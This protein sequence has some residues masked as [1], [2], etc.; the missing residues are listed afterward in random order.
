MLTLDEA[1]AALGSIGQEHVLRFWDGLGGA[2]RKS[3]LAQVASLNLGE[4]PTLIDQYV[5]RRPETKLPERVDPAPYYPSNPGEKRSRG[6]WDSR[7]AQA[8]GEALLSAGRVAC[9]TVAGGQG[10]RLGYEGP[11]GCYPAGAVTGK[12]LF[13]FF[14]EGILAAKD[15]YGTLPPWYVMTSPQNHDATLAFFEQHRYFGLPKDGVTFFPQGVMAS[16]DMGSGRMLMVA[17]HEIATNPDGHGGAIRALVRSGATADMRKR[18]VEHISY[19]QVDNPI[20]RVLDPL[21][22]GLHAGASDSSAEMSSKMIPKAYAEEKLGLFCSVGGRTVVIEYSD[23]PMER[24]RETLPDGTLRFRAGSIAVHTLGVDFVERLERDPNA[25]LP[26]HRADKKVPC[27]DPES[28]EPVNPSAPNGVK[29]ERFVFDALAMCRASIVL[30]TSR[31][32]EFAP[33]KNA[34]GVDSPASSA[35]I[36]T[37][38]AAGW[39]E[40]AGVEIPRR[41]EPGPNG[42][43]RRVPDC[44]IELSPRTASSAEDV[45]R[46]GLRPK[47]ERGARV[48]L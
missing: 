32:E 9:F 22:L 24:Q 19:F 26:F 8:R 40:A 47:I 10:S 39:L 5:K 13:Q 16:I 21:F 46:Q 28:G 15:L 34:E 27:I 7:A 41:D 23:L 36:Q 3:L 1:R 18:G 30:E 31:L 44:V 42:T 29:L 33:I 48:A 35:A 38:R 37:E 14:A 12:S 2:E 6:P 43:T 4:L 17:K 11:K 25:Q 45:L 20:V